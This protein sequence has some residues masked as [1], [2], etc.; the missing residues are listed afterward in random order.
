MTNFFIDKAGKMPESPM[1][2]MNVLNECKV[3]EKATDADVQGFLSHKIPTNRSG[4]C[5]MTCVLEKNGD[6]NAEHSIFFYKMPQ[7]FS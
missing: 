1:N 3:Q 4:K 5:L 6:V 2:L 7:I